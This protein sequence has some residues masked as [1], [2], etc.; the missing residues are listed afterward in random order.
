MDN[1]GK[2]SNIELNCGPTKSRLRLS[3]KVAT[4]GEGEIYNVNV[5]QSVSSAH[6]GKKYVAKIYLKNNNDY[7]NKIQYM[8]NYANSYDK[9]DQHRFYKYFEETILWP[10]CAL[11]NNGNFMGY[12][13]KLFSGQKLS[14][15]IKVPLDVVT[16]KIFVGWKKL[17]L[18]KIALDIAKKVNFLHQNN[19]VLGDIDLDNIMLDLK[20]KKSAIVDTDSFQ[21][22]NFICPVA[23]SDSAPPEVH[24]MQKTGQIRK[25]KRSPQ[26]DNYSLAVVIFEI[27][28]LGYHPFQHK[29]ANNNRSVEIDNGNFRYPYYVTDTKSISSIPSYEIAAIWSHLPRYIRKNFINTFSRN[30]YNNKSGARLTAKAWVIDLERYLKELSSGSFMKFDQEAN[31]LAPKK[32]KFENRV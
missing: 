8:I 20:T 7:K 1:K 19:I 16:S 11:D 2:Y 12:T 18:V 22:G 28:M 32:V 21:I 27:L 31:S 15:Y 5:I 10:L 24:Y 26:S 29:N 6:Q 17:D 25:I 13:M 14:G 4:G 30:G 9:T 23:H 3:S